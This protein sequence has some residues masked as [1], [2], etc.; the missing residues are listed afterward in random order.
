MKKHVFCCMT[1]ALALFT[2]SSVWSQNLGIKG[3]INLASISESASD[4]LEDY[5]DN[6]IVGIQAGLVAELPISDFFCHS[7]RITLGAKRW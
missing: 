7:A 4:D 5:K 1:L 2:A 6:A 3:G